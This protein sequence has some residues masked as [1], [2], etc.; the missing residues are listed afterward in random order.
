MLLGKKQW[1]LNPGLASDPST[2]DPKED[3]AEFND[4]VQNASTNLQKNMG[5]IKNNI[6]GK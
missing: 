4:L 6:F 1:T 2:L 5:D 3:P